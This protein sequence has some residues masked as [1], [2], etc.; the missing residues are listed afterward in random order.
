M[1]F[2]ISDKLDWSVSKRQLFFLD[3]TGTP[4]PYDQKMAV[5]R[6]DND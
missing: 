6:E 4:V 5:I 3:H 2:S 1:Q